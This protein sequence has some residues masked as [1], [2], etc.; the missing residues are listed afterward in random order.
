MYFTQSFLLALGIPAAGADEAAFLID[1]Q[2]TAFRALPGQ[3]FGQT[4]VRQL[5]MAIITTYMFFQNTGN[6]I[7]AGEHRLAILPGN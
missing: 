4:I 3:V 2:V 6:G 1:E 5:E 7:G